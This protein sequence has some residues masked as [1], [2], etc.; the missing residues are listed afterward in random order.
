MT[1]VRVLTHPIIQA[2]LTVLRDR[3][4]P[5]EIF[6]TT[7]DELTSLMAY[8]VTREFPTRPID[9]ETPLE[10]TTGR[11]LDVSTINVVTI[12]RAGLGM[13]GGVVRLLPSVRVG[14]LGFER[15]ERTLEAKF[16]YAKIPAFDPRTRTV[17]LD[18]ML[19]TG[20]TA[21]AALEY[22]RMRG[23]GPIEFACI[24]AAPEG[25]ARVRGAFPDVP[26]YTAAL[27]RE[28]NGRGYILPGLGDAGDRIFGTEGVGPG[29]GGRGTRVI[30]DRAGGDDHLSSRRME[31]A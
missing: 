23:V 14:V 10:R 28:L 16:Y 12:L 4:T 19:A 22:L 31:D 26:I 6:K 20:G 29:L 1:Q 3:S 8:E 15:D 25:V 5:T 7:V 9:V 11:V 21:V 13:L 27:D 24:I 2:K 17:L 30:L 18:P